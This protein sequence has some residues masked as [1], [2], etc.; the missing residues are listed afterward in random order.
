MTDF[1]TYLHCKPDGTPFYVGKGCGGRS[2]DLR[3]RNTQHKAIVAKYGIEIFVFPCESEEQAFADEVQMI[4]QFK[5]EGFVLANWTDGGEGASGA[6]RS[7]ETK[8][9]MSAKLIGNKRF[10]GKKHSDETKAKQAAANLGIK[11]TPEACAKRSA[12][13]KRIMQDSAARARSSAAAK[14]QAANTPPEVRAARA[15]A[16]S[17]ARWGRMPK[18]K[19]TLSA[20]VRAKISASRKGTPAW[21]KGLRKAVKTITAPDQKKMVTECTELSCNHLILKE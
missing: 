8:A 9:L 7:D 14:E 17:K 5:R 13:I 16:A 4:A 10:L 6:V 21:N 1:Y 20:E 15:A 3:Q 2:H 12:A 11:K 19:R 18:E